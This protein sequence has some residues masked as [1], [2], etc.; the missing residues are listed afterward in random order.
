MT[1]KPSRNYVLHAKSK[2]FYWAGDGQLSIKTFRNGRAHYKTSKG[3]FAVEEGRYLLLNEGEYTISIE[4]DEDVESFCIFFR[5]GFGEEIL[6]TF[7]DSTD[8][9]LSDP[10]KEMASIGF[11]EKTY[12]TSHTLASQLA[13]LKERLTFLDRDS[14]GYEEQFHQ[15]MRTILLGHF[16]VRKEMDA[17]HALRQS[18]REELYRRTSTAHDYIRAFYDQPIRL[19]EIA[20]IASLSPNHLLRA[21]AQV[22]GKTPHQH[23]SEY[24][25]QRAKQLL[26]KLDFS[27][28]DIAFELGFS[29]P[30]SFSKMFKQHVGI[31]PL[32]FRKKVILDKK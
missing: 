27:M 13:I 31:S 5:H 25:I 12:H 26:A 30:V 3:F 24:R 8:R 4:E 10:Y 18:T 17:L 23:I 6:S 2:Q 14:I 7:V 19:D 11:F 22:Y 32:S 9:L 29:N 16:D 20:K 28:T 1:D 21:Y 15:I